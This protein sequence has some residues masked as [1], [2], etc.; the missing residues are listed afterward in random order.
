MNENT[1]KAGFT[2]TVESI[3][4]GV[5]I[6]TETTHN[7]FPIEGLNDMLSVWL[8]SGTQSASWYVGLYEGNYTPIPGDTAAGF[9]AASTELTAYDETTRIALVLGTV[10]GGG[11]DNS[12]SPAVFTGSTNGKQVMGGF[13]STAPAK[14]ATTGVLASAVR[15]TSPK[16]LDDGTVLRVTCSFQI[17]SA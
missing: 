10:S 8:K 1:A 13:I 4:D 6:D 14:G 11:V 5:V 2:W 15:F 7:L 16:S 9:P 12:A 17:V 3:R